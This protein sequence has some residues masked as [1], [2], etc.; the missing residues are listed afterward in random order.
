MPDFYR[1]PRLKID[2]RAA[3]YPTVCTSAN[4]YGTA[5]HQTRI[6][7]PF[8]YNAASESLGTHGPAPLP[9]CAPLHSITKVTFFSKCII[10]LF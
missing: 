9:L 6:F 2:E 4:A 3:L 10:F 8:L 5:S 7:L 1:S